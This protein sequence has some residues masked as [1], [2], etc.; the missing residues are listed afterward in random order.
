M[1]KGGAATPA[2]PVFLYSRHIRK[3]AGQPVGGNC[4]PS[5][6]SR[7]EWWRI[8]VRKL[9]RTALLSAIALL[10]VL[11]ATLFVLSEYAGAIPATASPAK[12][13]NKVKKRKQKILKGRRGKHSRK[14]A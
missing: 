6:V 2:P 8:F 7:E 10:S 5:P 11:P 3:H 4:V 12:K 14:P 1:S 13:K 9:C